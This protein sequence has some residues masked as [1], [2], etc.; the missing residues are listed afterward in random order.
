MDKYCKFLAVDEEQPHRWHECFSVILSQQLTTINDGRGKKDIRSF[1][2][3]GYIK[4]G[5]TTPKK[6]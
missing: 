6:R 3:Q 1:L 4:I 2:S 5:G